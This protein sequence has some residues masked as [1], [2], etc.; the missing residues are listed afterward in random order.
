LLRAG[1]R[2]HA[3]ARM[4]TP[5]L[6]FRRHRRAHNPLLPADGEMRR[7][8]FPTRKDGPLKKNLSGWVRVGPAQGS[9]SNTPGGMLR[10]SS[11]ARVISFRRNL[12][13]GDSPVLAANAVGVTNT[14]Q[15]STAASAPRKRPATFDIHPPRSRRLRS[16]KFVGGPSSK[17]VPR[18]A[19]S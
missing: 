12:R 2:L 8:V 3:P 7:D 11:N 18:D 13:N 5:R 10:R 1:W 15:M 4:T 17:G 19:K 14:E 9:G 16:A 6:L